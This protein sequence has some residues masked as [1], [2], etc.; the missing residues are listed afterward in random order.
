[1]QQ[2]IYRY[3]SASYPQP[4]TS[5]SQNRTNFRSAQIRH[6]RSKAGYF[7]LKIGFR[8]GS[9]RPK[10][11]P[12]LRSTLCIRRRMS[13]KLKENYKSRYRSQ[14]GQVAGVIIIILGQRHAHA[15]LSWSMRSEACHVQGE[16]GT[17]WYYI[18]FIH[19]FITIMVQT[20]LIK[21]E[22]KR[23]SGEPFFQDQVITLICKSI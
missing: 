12:P 9:I 1:M 17:S 22:T 14:S 16:Q 20:Q 11:W 3:R 2:V 15:L 6:S 10:N 13:P 21:K 23:S 4:E 19:I 8:K 5:L 18:Q 7:A